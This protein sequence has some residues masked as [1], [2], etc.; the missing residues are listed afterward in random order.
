MRV[1]VCGGRRYTD[2]QRLAW[3]LDAAHAAHGFDELASGAASGADGLA[4]AWARER[5][6]PARAY[7]A[8]WKGEGRAAGPARN[9]RMLADFKPELVIAFPGGA[10]TAHMMR[11]ARA[12]GVWTV[13][14]EP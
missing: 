12:A 9:R 13:E 10:G 3:V 1:L 2:W 8:D 14:V 7:P 6:V 4:L 11:I 5:G